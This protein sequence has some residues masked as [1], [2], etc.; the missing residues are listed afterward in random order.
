MLLFFLGNRLANVQSKEVELLG[1]LASVCCTLGVDSA[2][3]VL[4]GV[5]CTMIC[6]TV[7]GVEGTTH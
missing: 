1:L 7:L 3:V 4:N 6:V 2:P 5:L